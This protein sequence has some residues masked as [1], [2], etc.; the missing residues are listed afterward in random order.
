VYKRQYVNYSASGGTNKSY[1]RGWGTSDDIV[2]KDR[3]I[4]ISSS[5][6]TTGQ[7]SKQLVTSSNVFYYAVNGA[8]PADPAFKPGD[9]TQ[10][11]IVYGINNPG[12]TNPALTMPYNRADYYIK[13]PSND[14]DIPKACNPKT[15]ILYKAVAKNGI[16]PDTVT[17]PNETPEHMLLYPLLD[18]V[19]DMQVIY[20]TAT[21]FSEVSGSTAADVRDQLRAVRV[22]I[23]AHEGHLDRN[24]TY[25]DS[26]IRVGDNGL[27]RTWSSDNMRQVFGDDWKNY[28]WKVYTI[29]ARPKNLN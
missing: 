5:F 10:L 21:G 4:T 19:G 7:Q 12:N 27:G 23:L 8:E 11:F 28:R 20:D 22:Y 24:Y 18:C 3:V 25:P 17:L 29:I 9:A 6:S 1:V 13:R 16:A 15:G 26:E 14:A 2:N